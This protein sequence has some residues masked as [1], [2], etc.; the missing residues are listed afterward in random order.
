M[1]AALRAS[2]SLCECLFEDHLPIPHIDPDR[3]FRPELAFEYR[4]G[5]GVL[6]LRL[7]RPLERPRAEHR[8]EADRSDL[9][10][11]GIGYFELHVH[12]RQTFLQ[13]SDLDTR[14]LA[15]VALVER[16]EHDD[17]V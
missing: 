16:M 10:Q 12:R 7:D 4:A 2:G 9:L 11:R 15:D 17:L 1:A 6:D 14:D 5:E 13:V 3:V 8:I